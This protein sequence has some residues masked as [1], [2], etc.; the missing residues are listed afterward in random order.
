[1][2]T[3]IEDYENEHCQLKAST[4]RGILRE[5]MAARAVTPSELSNV[6]GSKS[7]VS[8]VLSGKREISN[9]QAKKLATFFDVS[10][11]LFI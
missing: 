4:P 11:E 5:L 1:M 7:H 8:E 3:L 2:V 9:A 10:V 6:I